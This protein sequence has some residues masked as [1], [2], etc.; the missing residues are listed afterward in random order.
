MKVENNVLSPVHFVCSS[1][2]TQSLKAVDDVFNTV[3][4][5][6]TLPINT[7]FTLNALTSIVQDTIDMSYEFPLLGECWIAIPYYLL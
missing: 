2:Q 3:V 4:F 1:S 6:V 7:Y 5:H